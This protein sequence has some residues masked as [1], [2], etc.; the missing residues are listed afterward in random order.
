MICVLA[1]NYLEAQRWAN[2]QL[3]EDDEWFYP[4]SPDDLMRKENFHTVVVGTAGQNVPPSYF[5]KVFSLAQKQ[6]RKGRA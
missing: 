4:T 1:G 6:G 2:G 5:E 3:L